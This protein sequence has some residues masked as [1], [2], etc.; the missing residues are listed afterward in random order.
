MLKFFHA[1]PNK[2]YKVSIN[3]INIAVLLARAF[4]NIDHLRSSLIFVGKARSL[5][6]EWMHSFILHPCPQILDYGENDLK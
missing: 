5:P 6:L 2:A 4:V 1:G 3:I